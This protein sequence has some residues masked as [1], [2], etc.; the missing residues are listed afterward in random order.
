MMKKIGVVGGLF[1]SV[2]AL[3]LAGSDSSA[4]SFTPTNYLVTLNSSAVSANSNITVDY[5]LES[6]NAFAGTHVS[7]LP[8][9]FGASNGTAVPT[10]ADVGSLS[11]TATESSSNSSC[12]NQRSLGYQL[13]DASTDTSSGNT[14]SDSPRIPSASWPGFL[15][16]APSN[17]LADAVDK[18]PNF[19]KT[20][21]PGL[22]PRSRAFGWLPS[23]VATISRAVNVLV[24]DPGTALPGMTFPASLGYIVVVVQQDPTAPA[25]TSV[26][27]EACTTF[28]YIRQDRG[29]TDNNPNTPA[30]EGGV[31]YR[32]NPSANGSYS[33]MEYL[34]STRDHDNDAIENEL[35]SCPF[36]SN[37]SW[38]PRINDPVFDFDSDGIP[39]QDNPGQSGEQLLAGTG[40][41][42]T[43][44]TA[45]TDA[46]GDAYLNRQDN[47][48]LTAN[49]TSQ[50]NQADAD[51]DG[52]GDLCD[53]VDSA[54]D[55]HLHEVCIIANVTIGSGGSPTP[56]TCPELVLDMDNDGFTKSV[57]Q[58]VGTAPDD[59]CGQTAW[60]ADLYSSGMSANDVDVQDITSFL[61]PV[62][63]L[64]TDVDNNPPGDKR[65]DIVP[66]DGGVFA[67]DI[68]IQDVTQLL[69]VAPPMLEGPRAFGG[70]PCPYAP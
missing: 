36:V 7:F 39:G 52:I 37:P 18:Y 43:P 38:N 33:F 31:V 27:S 11:I 21:Y 6:P 22:T 49:G 70:P 26:V 20:L 14:L 34:R 35:D 51:K 32:T 44:L 58:H 10:G 24:F 5:T 68:N 60:P 54:P 63:Y 1:A 42:P 65:W 53:V 67:D 57:E 4:T 55:G 59:P 9:A 2:I 16:T 56:P 3:S 12:S 50:G 13:F 15:D 29:L 25:A 28:Q 61:A 64:N 45:N 19:L 46:D 48:P 47:C 8:S 62:R 41:D 17:G 23:S 69:V 30:N 66:G 40:C